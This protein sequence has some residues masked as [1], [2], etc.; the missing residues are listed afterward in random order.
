M[1]EPVGERPFAWRGGLPLVALAGL[2]AALVRAP[3][4]AYAIESTHGDTGIVALMMRRIWRGEELPLYYYGQGYMGAIDPLMCA[5]FVGALGT[6]FEAL[7]LAQTAIFCLLAIPLVYRLFFDIGGRVGATCGTSLVA[8]G[9][10][11]MAI[12]TGGRYTGYLSTFWI[13]TL[14]LLMGLAGLGRPTLRQLVAIGFVFGLG[15]YNNPQIAL[16]LIPLAIALG[17][18]HGR[19]PALRA[20]GALSVAVGRGRYRVVAWTM[21]LLAVAI[22]LFVFLSFIHFEARRGDFTG[23][24]A[25][26][27]LGPLALSLGSPSH[28]YVAWRGAPFLTFGSPENYLPRL[29]AGELALGLVVEWWLVR[30]RRRWLRWLGAFGLA[31]LVGATPMLVAK[32]R[33]T[34]G[35]SAPLDMNPAWIPWRWEELRFGNLA[36]LGAGEEEPDARQP[37]WFWRAEPT[38]EPWQANLMRANV[39]GRT[40]AHGVWWC[41]VAAWVLHRARDYWA[42]LRLRPVV[43]RPLDLLLIQQ[44]VFI[45]LYLM[46]PLW[47]S[48]RYFIFGWLLLGGLV[49]WAVGA[50]HRNGP[51]RW[52][53]RA[54]LAVLVLHYVFQHAA[55]Y[56]LRLTDGRRLPEAA[57]IARELERRGLRFGIADYAEAYHL[58]FQSDERLV[59]VCKDKSDERLPGNRERM[60]A[61]RGRIFR[62]SADWVGHDLESGDG[63]GLPNFLAPRGHEIATRW[64]Y[65]NYV[66]YE[67][68]KRGLAFD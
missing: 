14:L 29:V 66:V 31:A 34:E 35:R 22:E 18:R 19:V 40:A 59:V 52:P 39:G 5:P 16:F 44:A 24:A 38:A 58:L 7:A 2:V 30:D 64:R 68:E 10:P 12:C 65:G 56:A 4:V 26:W 33:G 15:W 23:A 41:L 50:S 8:L 46:H 45:S 28:S 20:A 42:A 1:N 3:I 63:F 57:T 25:W 36:W 54:M 9:T 13:G 43:L 60:F 51:W 27:E 32:W 53:V 61:H 67:Y 55:Y 11:W 21:A 6:R 37:S 48:G 47:A 17:L 49:A 62:L